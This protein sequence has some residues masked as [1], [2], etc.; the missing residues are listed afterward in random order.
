MVS[1]EVVVVFTTVSV[2]GGAGACTVVVSAL[3]VSAV[4]SFLPQAATEISARV[5]MPKLIGFMLLSSRDDDYFLWCFS[6]FL[7]AL[8]VSAIAP[9]A[10]APVSAG[11]V[12]A[13]LVVAGD[14]AAAPVSVVAGAGAGAG[15]V[16][17]AVSA[18]V[19]SALALFPLLHAARAITASATTPKLV[20]FMLP[21]T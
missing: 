3:V 13:P 6:A 17:A 18:D 21:P 7:A 12:M 19:L 8:P 1:V 14:I 10:A 16:A 9:P 20:L 11:E 5:T 4:L 2:T 15:A